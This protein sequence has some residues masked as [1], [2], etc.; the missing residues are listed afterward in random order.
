[1]PCR[2]QLAVMLNNTAAVR[3]PLSLPTNNQSLLDASIARLRVREAVGFYA[4][5]PK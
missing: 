5:H 2:L 4:N 3:P 1:M